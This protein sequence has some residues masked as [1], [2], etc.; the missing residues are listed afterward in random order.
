MQLL[1]AGHHNTSLLDPQSQVTLGIQQILT[2]PTVVTGLLELF[3]ECKPQIESLTYQDQFSPPY[4]QAEC[5]KSHSI[6][7]SR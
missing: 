6:S 3:H 1:K 2:P 4:L 5:L 7:L